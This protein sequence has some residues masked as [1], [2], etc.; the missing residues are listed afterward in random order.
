MESDG[1]QQTKKAKLEGEED[2]SKPS[3]DDLVKK[4]GDL[5]P[6]LAW[7]VW[8]VMY[9][10]ERKKTQALEME[11][12]KYKDSGKLPSSEETLYKLDTT[13]ITPF[14]TRYFNSLRFS[15]LDERCIDPRYDPQYSGFGYTRRIFDSFNKN[16]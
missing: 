15:E 8:V 12:K 9:S 7:R 5:D 11:L 6:R 2:K 10:E 14:G 13:T 1:N 3:L 4:T 16:K